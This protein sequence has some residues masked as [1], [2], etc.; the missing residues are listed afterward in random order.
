[1]ANSRGDFFPPHSFLEDDAQTRAKRFLIKHQREKT[2]VGI[3][4]IETR[5]A[6]VFLEKCSDSGKL[7]YFAYLFGDA[8]DITKPWAK[9]RSIKGTFLTGGALGEDDFLTLLATNVPDDAT[10]LFF[11]GDN[12][13]ADAFVTDFNR[14]SPATQENIPFKL[15]QSAMYLLMTAQQ[16]AAYEES[17]LPPPG[18]RCSIS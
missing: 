4:G 10:P 8:A 14:Y 9:L 5:K 17:K 15:E 3:Y 11:Q 16:R 1:M 7:T 12:V 6:M 13:K 18:C 2:I